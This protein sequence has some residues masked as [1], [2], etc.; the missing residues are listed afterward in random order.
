MWKQLHVSTIIREDT[1]YMFPGGGLVYSHVCFREIW[2]GNEKQS[3]LLSREHAALS[4]QLAITE[5][6]S[7]HE[8]AF[9]WQAVQHPAPLMYAHMHALCVCKNS[10]HALNCSNTAY[11]PQ[12]RHCGSQHNR[13]AGTEQERQSRRFAHGAVAHLQVKVWHCCPLYRP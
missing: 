3:F 4:A 5:Q 8:C 13:P 10:L 11:S 7:P 2:S 12:A 1:S 6:I 9:K